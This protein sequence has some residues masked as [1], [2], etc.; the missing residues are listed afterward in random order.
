MH[1]PILV[2]TA[3]AVLVPMA[4]TAGDPTPPRAAAHAGSIPLGPSA[5]AKCA[6]GVNSIEEYRWYASRAYK[7]Q[8]V[9][10]AA[11]KRMTYMRRCQHSKAAKKI[12]ARYRSRYKRE[13][14]NRKAARKVLALTRYSCSHGRWAIPCHIISCESG[15]SW[16]ATNKGG[17]GAIGPYQFLGW[18]VPWPINSEAD[19]LAHHRMAAKLWQGGAGRG[20]WAQCL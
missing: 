15:G 20:H 11:H 4:A 16:N 3:T 2:A 10:R 8:K 18:P 17:S 9:S 14:S 12:V 7:R 1:V 5:N 19:K 6:R 13:R